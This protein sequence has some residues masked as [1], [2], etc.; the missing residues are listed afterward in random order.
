M[1]HTRRKAATRGQKQDP[2]SESEQNETEKDNPEVEQSLEGNTGDTDHRDPQEEDT[3][4]WANRDPGRH[5]PT[6]SGHGR[7]EPEEP[8]KTCT[9]TED[10]TASE[11]EV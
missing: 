2:V 8:S 7:N 9:S 1:A 5:P 3:E 6:E 4:T 10:S 11:L